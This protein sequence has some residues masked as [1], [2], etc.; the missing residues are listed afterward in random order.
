MGS[1]SWEGMGGVG[2]VRQRKDTGKVEVMQFRRQSFYKHLVC[3]CSALLL[4][5]TLCCTPLDLA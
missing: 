4:Y 5:S 3:F 2:D 1:E